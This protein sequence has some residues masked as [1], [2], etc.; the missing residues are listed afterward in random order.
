MPKIIISG[1]NGRMGHVVT[2]MCAE[3][4][5]M[6]VVAGFDINTNKSFGYPVYSAPMEYTGPADVVIDFSNS[7]ALD[8]LLQYCLKRKLALV[9]CTTGHSP[10]QL[11]AIK[12]ASEQIP[13]FKSANMSLGVNLLANLLKKAAS[14]LGDNYDIEIVERHHKTKVDAPSGTAIMLADAVSEGLSFTPEYV[15]ERQ[16]VRKQRDKKEIGLSA[17]RGGTIVG[18]HEVLFCGPDEVIEFKHTAYSREVFANGAVTAAAFIS[19]ITKPGIYDM[20]D[21]LAEILNK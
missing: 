3:R 12:A 16:S 8:A 9:I 15:Y 13:V 18:D 2:R 1:C 11:G 14:V 19:N 6:N 5:G 17:V 7:A 21:A 10:E 20:N 4:E